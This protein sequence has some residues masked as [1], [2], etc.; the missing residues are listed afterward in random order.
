M[1]A[2]GELI[3]RS[4]RLGADPRNTNYAGGNASAKGRTGRS[5]PRRASATGCRGATS[6]QCEARSVEIIR[7][8]AQFIAESGKPDPFG[9]II[10]QYEPLPETAR[11][12]RAAELAPVIR[13]LACTGR[14]LVG[15]YTDSDVVLDF[16]ARAGHP[17]LAA[18]GT[19][20]S[21]TGRWR[22][23]SWPAC[24]GPGRW[25]PGSRWSPGPDRGSGGRSRCGW[26]PRGRACWSPT[27]TG[28]S[29]AVAAEIGGPDVAVPFTVDVT[30]EEQ[31]AAAVAAAALAFGGVDLVV[32]NAGLS[33]SEPL[34]FSVTG[35]PPPS[36]TCSSA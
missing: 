3:G 27:G 2:V 23:S 13:G 21:S 17:R 14:P 35:W 12:A 24:P 7:A 16:I 8:A 31:V 26:R 30:D 9:P 19:S 20:G 11:H 34:T 36:G 15:H 1:S 18:L 22:R 10:P 5:W 28:S 25:P 6:E 4:N 33:I 32:N 29:A